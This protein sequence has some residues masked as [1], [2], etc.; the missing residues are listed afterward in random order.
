VKRNGRHAAIWMSILAVRTTLANLDESETGKNGGNLPR[1]Q[2]GNVAHRLR[3][4][5]RLRSDEFSLE[6]RPA[7]LQQHGDDLCKVLAELV[8]GSALRVR[9]GPAGNVADEQTCGLVPLD[10]CREGLHVEMIPC[11]GPPNK[12]RKRTCRRRA[13]RSNIVTS[14]TTPAHRDLSL[15]NLRLVAMLR[16]SLAPSRVEAQV[17]GGRALPI[18][19]QHLLW[20]PQTHR[21][22][23]QAPAWRPPDR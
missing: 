9:T 22:R 13:F 18:R 12:M 14:S 2:N 17:A 15:C 10:D 3:D 19:P 1:L 23:M 4:L 7:I 20:S 21:R 6:L 5:H 11:E 8:E 16:T